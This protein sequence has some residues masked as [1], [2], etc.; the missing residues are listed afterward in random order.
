MN[1]VIK[2]RKYLNIY[3]LFKHICEN[4]INKGFIKSCS[5][6]QVEFYFVYFLLSLIYS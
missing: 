4:V 6:N 2:K 3:I 1:L 5:Q